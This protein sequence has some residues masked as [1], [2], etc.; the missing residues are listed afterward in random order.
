MLERQVKTPKWQPNPIVAAR[1]E[2]AERSANDL[3]LNEFFFEKHAAQRFLPRVQVA[4]DPVGAFQMRRQ[5]LGVPLTPVRQQVLVQEPK[6]SLCALQGHSQAC[7]QPELP[8][9]G[10][11]GLEEGALAAIDSDGRNTRIEVGNQAELKAGVNKTDTFK[12]KSTSRRKK[13]WS[14]RRRRLILFGDPPTPGSLAR[15]SGEKVLALT[16]Q[17]SDKCV[18]HRLHEEWDFNCTWAR[19]LKADNL[20]A[21]VRLLFPAFRLRLGQQ[22]TRGGASRLIDTS[23]YLVDWPSDLDA[24]QRA[25]NKAICPFS[26]GPERCDLGAQPTKSL[27]QG[28]PAQRGADEGAFVR[29]PPH[30]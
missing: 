25:I 18:L 3:T 22:Q 5:R 20:K 15:K 12:F 19:R 10:D 11:V 4:A 16:D 13:I 26:E 17:L 1:D 27:I 23:S 30:F 14:S 28:P 6:R 29:I 21:R 2:S 7:N 8:E 9:I 24:W